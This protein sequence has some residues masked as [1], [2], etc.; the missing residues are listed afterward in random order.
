VDPTVAR[1]PDKRDRFDPDD[2]PSD[3]QNVN[4]NDAPDLTG[5]EVFNPFADAPEP[6]APLV[7][8]A[9]Q[10]LVTAGIEKEL[11]LAEMRA[12]S[13]QPQVR[14]TDETDKTTGS[15]YVVVGTGNCPTE[16][17]EGVTTQWNKRS[18]RGR[19]ARFQCLSRSCPV[20]GDENRRPTAQFMAESAGP[21]VFTAL[22]RSEEWDRVRK[23]ITRAGATG[24]KVPTT[25]GGFRIFTTEPVVPSQRVDD[26]ENAMLKALEQHERQRRMRGDRRRIAGVNGITVA[27]KR[28]KKGKAES[29]WVTM[30]YTTSLP[31]RELFRRLAEGGYRPRD[32]ASDE[33]LEHEVDAF[34]FEMPPP[35][36][37]EFDLFTRWLGLTLIATRDEIEEAA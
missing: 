17:S 25:A 6:L 19:F 31:R 16:A 21:V 30:P 1:A 15:S 37:E 35:D 8:R 22:V 28:A 36:S 4:G 34:V 5:V 11:R 32:V 29:G 26:P 27:P 33:L 20:H 24:Y 7:S 12:M 2:T 10:R 18:G 23:R 9:D 3:N 13:P 14:S